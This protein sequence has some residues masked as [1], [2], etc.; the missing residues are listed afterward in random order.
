[1]THIPVPLAG[2]SGHSLPDG[3]AASLRPTRVRY[4]VLLLLL[5]ATILNYVDRSA[6]GIVAPAI[7]HDLG[8]G[9][10]QMGEL[11]AAFGAAY[12]IALIPGGVLA[13]VL[14]VRLTYALSLAGWS[15]ATMTQAFA[16]GY[17]MLLGS[18][19]AIGA[20]EAPAFPSNARAVTMWFPTRERGFASSV[21]VTGQYIGTPMFTGLLLW[22]ASA[23]GWRSVFLVN[24]LLGILLG[25]VW[26]AV[27]RAPG[28]HPA[29]NAAELDYITSGRPQD[30]VPTRDRFDWAVAFRLLRYRQVLAICLG[31]FCN[32][33]LLVFFTTWF[34]TYLVEDRHL[35]VIKVG[36]FQAL[37]FIGATI[38]TLA[39]GY[40]SDFFIR[41][42]TSMS[43]ARKAP[44]IIGTVLGASIVLVNLVDS[45]EAMI[46]I[47]TVAFFAQ[48]IGS[49]SW[50]AVS[51]IAP[52]QYVGLTSS[53]TSLA[54]N[55]A[56]VTTPLMIG[57]VLHYTGTF[58]WAL[59]LMGGICLV[60]A[61][62][63]SVLLGRLH[64]I[65]L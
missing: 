24:G 31:K 11:F 48:G 12:S 7:S 41:R 59:N 56:A 18:R 10:L 25:A 55:L 5:L 45:N 28:K 9:K 38:G 44:L 60:G 36:I 34:M 20:L 40:F 39:A 21:Y 3:A 50:A 64:R 16:N 61:F 4:V 51:E 57:V 15:L 23:Y 17:Q 49:S 35:S 52:R 26:Y 47:L 54:A 29:V 63:Y 1:M 65:E 14:G 13:D 58:V 32:N 27:Y 53:I 46:A 62:S 43:A 8:L 33:T 22:I 42:G 37:P 30:G 19:V 2:V 6:L